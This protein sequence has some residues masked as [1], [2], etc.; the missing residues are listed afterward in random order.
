MLPVCSATSSRSSHS[1]ITLHG[2]LNAS[3]QFQKD[4]EARYTM[5]YRGSLGL[6]KAMPFQ[7]DFFK[8]HA[9]KSLYSNFVKGT[10][11]SVSTDF[12][13]RCSHSYESDHLKC[14]YSDM[15]SSST[16]TMYEQHPPG[17]LEL[18]F[19]DSSSLLAPDEGLVD[20]TNPSTG[21][22]SVLPAAVEPESISA[23]D[24]TP[25]NS[26]SVPD[27]LDMDTDRLSGVKTS[28]EDFIDGVSKSFS[29]SVEKGEDIVKTSVDTITSSITSVVTNATEAVDNTVG[30]LFSTVDQ[31]GQYGGSKMTK[32]SSDFKE[33]TSKGAVVA[34]DVLRRSIVVV[35][36]SLSNGASFA[37]SSY[38]SAKAFLPPDI[39]DALNLSEKRVAE[40]LGPAKTAFQ[41]VYISIEGLEENLGLDPND[42]IILFVLFLGTSATLWVIYRVWTYSGFAGDLSP[43]LTLEL[44][45]GKENAVLIDVRPE[46]LREREG[47]PDLRRAARFR[48]A[49]VSLPEVDGAVWKLVKS[50]RDLND[51]LTAAVIRNLKIVQDRSKVIVM[52][53]DGTRS[54]GIARSLRKLGLK[55]PYLVQ[56]GFKSWVK[57]GLRI[58]ELKPETA[59]TILNEEAEA[60]LED[61]SPSPVQVLGSGVGLIAAFYALLEWEKTL[62]LIGVVGVGQTI[63]RRVASYETAEDF[64]KDVRLLLSPVRLGAQAFSWTAGQ[65]ESNGIGLPTSP[66][67]SDVKNRVLQAAAK[68]ESQPSDTEGIQDPSTDSKLPIKESAD[69]SEA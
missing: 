9:T 59:F 13:N 44:L 65:L 26:T 17:R 64:K 62:Q 20:F 48:Y 22:A 40:F 11:Q 36:D 68:H 16:G 14:K 47:I 50:G 56:G 51:T 18:K 1:Q 7:R 21:N 31:T 46:V 24:L 53:A 45:T 35:E 28:I 39:S 49:S 55:K 57:N 33:A 69:L 58:K 29:A 41:Q 63:Y 66:S 10:E 15:W 38:Q 25:G 23:T 4:F 42:P 43:Q 2:G 54:K 12:V 27:S 19:V 8:A 60:I 67:S 61:I 5:G 6:S 32:F 30:G 34:I 3:S 52:D 37:V